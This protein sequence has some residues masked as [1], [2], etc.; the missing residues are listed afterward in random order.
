[1]ETKKNFDHKLI[2]QLSHQ[3]EWAGI[4]NFVIGNDQK[5]GNLVAQKWK[6]KLNLEK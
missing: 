4:L 5:S 3:Q 2:V 6:L 1:M